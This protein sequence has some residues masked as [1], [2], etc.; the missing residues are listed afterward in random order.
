MLWPRAKMPTCRWDLHGCTL[1]NRV[2][3]GQRLSP[4]YP[5]VALD[6]LVY[7]RT[8]VTRSS[9]VTRWSSQVQPDLGGWKEGPGFVGMRYAAS[10]MTIATGRGGRRGTGPRRSRPAERW[11]SERRCGDG[12]A[13]R[14]GTFGRKDIRDTGVHWPPAAVRL[15]EV[16]PGKSC[17]IAVR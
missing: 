17:A 8:V 2:T 1:H 14:Y 4:H 5:Q 3:V 11:N 16:S 9:S 12:N 7:W 6:C 10:I 13:T 15:G